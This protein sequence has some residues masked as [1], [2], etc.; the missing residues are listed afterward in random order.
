[1]KLTADQ[2][3]AAAVEAGNLIQGRIALLLQQYS[4]ASY[5]R[6]LD[7]VEEFDSYLYVPDDL[8][9]Q[10]D[11]IASEHGSDALEDFH[12]LVLATLVSSHVDR[13]GLMS[14]HEEHRLELLAFFDIVLR[15]I[16]AGKR[17]YFLHGKDR[18]AKSLA[19][20]RLK[21]LPCGPILADIKFG[22]IPRRYLL[23]GSIA[24]IAGRLRFLFFKAG[25]IK[26]YL[27]LHMEFRLMRKLSPEGM[28]QAYKLLAKLLEADENK[29][30]I[31]VSGAWLF[32][33]ALENISPELSYLR[34]L[35]QDNGAIFIPTDIATSSVQD[36]L[37]LSP[38]R[39]ALHDA[40]EYNPRSYILVWRRADVIQ[41]ANNG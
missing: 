22:S 35:P 29:K 6:R 10:C 15:E 25:S 28:Q 13:L 4:V 33:P 26:N 18:F 21:M 3:N 11:Q 24:A 1:M 7:V 38:H 27:D 36:A 41:W 2:I 40:G 39:K 31:L 30:G 14:L 37:R 32:D 5:I 9:F 8:L 34:Q 17:N 19:V 12:R 16:N 23:S 20:C